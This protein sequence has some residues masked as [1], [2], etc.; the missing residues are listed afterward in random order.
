VW[1]LLQKLW[2]GPARENSGEPGEALAADW[3][4]RE[5]RCTIV[6]RNWRNPRDRREELDLVVRDGDVLVFVEVKTRSAAALVQGYH[7]VDAR[8]RKVLLRAA[9]AYLARLPE[10]PATYRFDVVEVEVPAAGLAHAEVRHFENVPLFP[11][12]YRD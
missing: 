2:P 1:A 4:R 7:A 11:K 3:L 8:K 12:R 9:G 5:R 6:A 10:K